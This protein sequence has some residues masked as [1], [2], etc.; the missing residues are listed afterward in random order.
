MTFMQVKAGCNHLNSKW[1]SLLATLADHPGTLSGLPIQVPNSSRKF[2]AR[3]A[4]ICT[5]NTLRGNP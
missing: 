4:F 1:L 3:P 2:P 5:E